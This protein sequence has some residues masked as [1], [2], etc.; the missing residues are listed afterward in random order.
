M[1]AGSLRLSDVELLF[2]IGGAVIVSVRLVYPLVPLS[3]S[4]TVLRT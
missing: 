1:S 4:T 3:S 2:A